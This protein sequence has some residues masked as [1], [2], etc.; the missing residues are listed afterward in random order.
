MVSASR[1]PDGST[2]SY[3]LLAAVSGVNSIFLVVSDL[4]HLI[5]TISSPYCVSKR[6]KSPGNLTNLLENKKARGRTGLGGLLR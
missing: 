3:S 2:Y 1:P 4:L 6:H 5:H